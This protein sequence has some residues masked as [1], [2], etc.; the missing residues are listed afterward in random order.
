MYIVNI[1]KSNYVL[2][3]LKSTLGWFAI[4]FAPLRSLLDCLAVAPE[5]GRSPGHQSAIHQHGGIGTFR[6]RHVPHVWEV[7]WM[8]AIGSRSKTHQKDPESIGFNGN[9]TEMW[10]KFWLN[11]MWMGENVR[12]ERLS[13]EHYQQNSYFATF[14]KVP[15]VTLLN[16]RTFCSYTWESRGNLL[17]WQPFPK[18]WRLSK[19]ATPNF[20]WPHRLTLLSRRCSAAPQ[21]RSW[22]LREAAQSP[23]SCGTPMV[24]HGW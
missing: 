16:L 20:G 11:V 13:R 1:S 2:N 23:G 4:P 10:K 14:E 8:E 24:D 17:P 19:S 15:R 12:F 22:P 7:G 18:R 21:L 9:W 6:G 5:V 3:I